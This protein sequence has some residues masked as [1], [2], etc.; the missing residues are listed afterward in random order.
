M[1]VRYTNMM[2]EEIDSVILAEFT[3]LWHGELV[4]MI[5]V[6]DRIGSPAMIRR[7]EVTFLNNN[8]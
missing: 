8:T 1:D 5:V 2:G 7:D 4:Q 3:I 6:R